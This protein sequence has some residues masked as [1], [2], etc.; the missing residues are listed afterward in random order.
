MDANGIARQ[1]SI[2]RESGGAGKAKICQL[3]AAAEAS[4]IQME[5]SELAKQIVEVA[6][7]LPGVAGVRLWQTAGSE[8]TVWQERGELPLPDKMA[9]KRATSGDAFVGTEGYHWVC[10][11]R[12]SRDILGV[13]ELCGSEPMGKNAKNSLENLAR[14]ASA[15]WNGTVHRQTA[16]ELSAIVEAT[17][18]L[19]STLDLSELITIILQL[20]TRLTGA[21][22]GTV[23]LVDRKQNEIWSL[24]G[25]GLEK[26]EIRLPMDR[27]IAGW[28]A[29][30]GKSV[31][32]EDVYRDPRFEPAVDRR[33]GYRTRNLLALPIRSKDGEIVGVLELINRKEGSFSASDEDSLNHLSD[34]VALALENA[35]LHRESLAKQRMERDLA[36]AHSVQR[37]LLPERPPDLAGFEISVAYTPSQMVGGDYYDFVPLNPGALLIVIAD[38]E[39]KGVASALMM[40]NLRATMHTLTAHVHALEQ[41]VKSVNDMIFSDRRRQKLVSMFVAILDQPRRGLHY[42]NAGHVPPTLIRAEGETVELRT[43]GTL[44]GAFSDATFTR[45]H[46]ELGQDDV[47]AGYTDGITEAMDA[48]GNQYGL[49][50][51]VNVVRRERAASAERIVETVLAEVDSFSR[52]G[53]HDDDRVIFILKVL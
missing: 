6:A 2:S 21:E 35:R 24:V 4:Q 31:R 50:R 38:V 49:G 15:A 19:N 18:S 7:A 10:L 22:R 12:C 11:V 48:N 1:L 47:L 30:H 14:I 29:R 46:I 42:I 28:V 40:A 41:I 23:F 53:H 39:G 5:L 13:L 8:P 32:L 36:L 25:L 27:G 52:G 33:L 17:K 3:Y 44:V 26:Q 9:I 51:L 34:H 20:A 43:G 37:G 45:G 16:E